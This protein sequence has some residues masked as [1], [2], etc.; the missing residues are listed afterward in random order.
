MA[1]AAS[2][3][4]P[5]PPPEVLGQALIGSWQNMSGFPRSRGPRAAEGTSPRRS[6]L[7][8]GP[9][10]STPLSYRL[11]TASSSLSRPSAWRS[12][13]A[14]ALPASPTNS[15]GGTAAP[16]SS[17]RKAS[18]SPEIAALAAAYV[19]SASTASAPRQRVRR[20]SWSR[21][22][23]ARRL[24][25]STVPRSS[26]MSESLSY[27]SRDSR[28]SVSRSVSCARTRA[29]ALRTLARPRAAARST[30]FRR[31]ARRS[32]IVAQS[33]S[34]A[35]TSS[36]RAPVRARMN[37]CARPVRMTSWSRCRPFFCTTHSAQMQAHSQVAQKYVAGSSG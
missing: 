18:R 8:L 26:R 16:V 33:S 36:M 24:V 30:S 17:C 15:S 32:A 20:L 10:K 23:S 1:A 4:C 37:S 28:S 27:E 34:S 9:V 22:S 7:T 3:G 13:S 35:T 19:L 5:G 11:D 6:P 14:R 21:R 12:S 31:H 29:K 25:C 2:T